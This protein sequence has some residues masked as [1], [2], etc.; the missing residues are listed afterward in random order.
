MSQ[1]ES[2]ARPISDEEDIGPYRMS[3]PVEVAFILRSLAQRAEFITIY[4]NGGRDLMLTRI[5]ESDLNKHEFI[6]DLSG[7]KASNIAIQKAERAIF[8]GL[9]DGVKV[10]FTTHSIREVDYEGQPAFAAPFPKDVIKLQ[11]RQFFRLLTPRTKPY[12]C[13]ITLPGQESMRLEIHD[14]SLGGMGIWFPTDL[15][16][17][18]EIGQKIDNVM[19]DLGPGGIMRGKIEIRNCRPVES[20]QGQTQYIVGVAFIGFTRAQE[21]NLQKLIS[22]LEK[23]RKALLG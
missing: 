10:Q 9:P 19:I 21:A 6:F 2:A 8:V 14:I 20:R 7:H 4:Y 1:E 17:H 3:S 11:R 16:D 5:L 13:R 22:Q 15:Y 12:I 23:E 18:I